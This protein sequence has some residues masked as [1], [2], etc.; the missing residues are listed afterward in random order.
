MSL[1]RVVM[2]ALAAWVLSIAYGAVVNSLVLQTQLIRYPGVFR[3]AHQSGLNLPFLLVGL[4][5]AMIAATAIYNVG[6]EGENGLA[7]GAR[8]GVLLGL[9]GDGMWFALYA[10]LNIGGRLALLGCLATLFE[11]FLVGL[12]IG[13]MPA[14]AMKT[15]VA[16]R[17]AHA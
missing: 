9:Y 10:A 5:L 7:E 6:H 13:L 16:S 17:V 8:F 14:S 15:S 12:V 2:P 3:S 1:R 4:L 11:G